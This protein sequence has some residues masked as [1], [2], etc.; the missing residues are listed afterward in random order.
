MRF[1]G[2]MQDGVVAR[3]QFWHLIGIL[4]RE[5]G[6]TFDIGEEKGDGAGRDGRELVL[7]SHWTDGL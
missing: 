1:D 4:L 6:A 2:L 5:P 7:V 3:K